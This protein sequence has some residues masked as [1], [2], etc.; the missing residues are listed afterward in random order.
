MNR[1]SR[2]YFFIFF[3]F[4]FLFYP[5]SH[6]YFK[7]YSFNHSFFSKKPL[8]I[9]YSF[10]PIPYLISSSFPQVSAEG[11]CVV[12]FD[13]FTPIFEK[14]CFQKFLPASTAKILTALTAWD[15]F[16]PYQVLVVKNELL[17]PQTMNLRQG[18]RILFENLLYGILVHSAND[19]AYAIADNFKG[20]KEKFVEAMNKKA[21]KIFMKNSFFKDLA[22]FDKPGQYTTP[23]DLLLAARELLKNKFLAKIVS[24]KA[25]TVSDV[26]FRFFHPLYNVNQLLGEIPGLGGIKTGYTQNAGENLVS[27]FKNDSYQYLIVVMKSQDRFEDTKMIINWLKVNVGYI[28]L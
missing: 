16:L 28:P 26:D 8:K 12:D 2:I 22:G 25:I 10:K 5:G 15:Y 4:F 19:A 20:G 9:N 14:N 24:T 7:I 3:T 27:Y 13:S 18:E 21:Q 1:I 6:L 23:F 11:A 17:E